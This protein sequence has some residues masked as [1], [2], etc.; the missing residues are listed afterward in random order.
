MKNTINK[1]T[2]IL[3]LKTKLS[4]RI[5][6]YTIMNTILIFYIN[7][8]KIVI[9]KTCFTIKFENDWIIHTNTRIWYS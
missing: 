3:T 9:N 2:C 7:S 5:S 6:Y 4:F 1:L 8:Y